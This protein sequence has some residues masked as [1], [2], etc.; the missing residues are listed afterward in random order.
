MELVTLSVNVHGLLGWAVADI[1]E[2]GRK[3]TIH[4]AMH[5]QLYRNPYRR[6]K[7]KRKRIQAV[8]WPEW[9]MTA[10]HCSYYGNSNDGISTKYA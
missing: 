4:L 5:D 6:G 3:P 9:S 2:Q 7:S 8:I 1:K 10:E